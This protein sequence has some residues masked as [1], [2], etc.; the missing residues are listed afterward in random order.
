MYVEIVS[1]SNLYDFP[2]GEHQAAI[3]TTNGIVKTNGCAV[4]GAGIA[5]YVRDTWYGTDKILGAK[6]IA[7]GNHVYHLQTVD[8][9][10]SHFQLISFPTKHD[11]REK[12]DI[13]LI[14]TSCIELIKLCTD[15]GI[16]HCYLCAPGCANGQL[17]YILDVR[18]VLQE[19]LSKA[20]INF[21]GVIATKFLT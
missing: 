1:N 12:S 8:F 18:P 7:G 9:N 2:D 5:K 21:I 15:M 13:E 17:S 20:N 6:L 16:T 10:G 3:V 19:E 4:M 11:Y 14:R